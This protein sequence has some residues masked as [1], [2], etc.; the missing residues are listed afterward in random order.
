M[1]DLNRLSCCILLFE[2][3]DTQTGAIGSVADCAT[4]TDSEP[5]YWKTA[6]GAEERIVQ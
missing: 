2:M 5:G 3:F 6:L 4:P 1:R